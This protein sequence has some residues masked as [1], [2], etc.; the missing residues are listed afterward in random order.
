MSV[1][2]ESGEGPTTAENMTGNMKV[3]YSLCSEARNAILA[4]KACRVL[5]MRM[6]GVHIGKHL[7]IGMGCREAGRGVWRRDGAKECHDRE[8]ESHTRTQRCVYVL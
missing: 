4:T 2:R 5:R 7:R 3:V 6:L 1:G 8:D